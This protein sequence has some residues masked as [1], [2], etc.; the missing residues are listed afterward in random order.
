[1]IT[2][3]EHKLTTINGD[4]FAVLCRQYLN[5]KYPFVYPTGLVVG[6]DKSRIGT[7]DTF[8]PIE[9]YYLF[10]EITTKTENVLTKLKN[11]I[12]HCF[13]QNDVP[14][15]KIVKVILMFNGVHD[16]VKHEELKTHLSSYSTD[17]RLEVIDIRILAN[18][19]SQNYPSLAR[20]LGVP[21]DTDQILEVSEFIKDYEKS[22]FAT[23]LSNKFF[24]REAEIEQGLNSLKEKDILLISGYAGTGKTKLSLELTKIFL[25]ENKEYDLK[26]I[27]ANANLDI[28]EDLQTFLL[29]EKHYLLVLDDAN[30]LKNNLIQILNFQ[31]RRDNERRIKIILTVRNYVKREVEKFIEDFK[32]IE[33]KPFTRDELRKVLQSNEYNISDYYV[34]RIFNISKGNPRLAIM[35]VTAEQS[36]ELEKLNNPSQILE[37]YFSSVKESID[38]FENKSLLAVA[39]ILSFFKTINLENEI[40]VQEIEKYFSISKL[41]LEQNLRILYD[42]EIADEFEKIY[43]VADQIL[44]EYILYLVFIKEQEISFSSL[45]NAYIDKDGRFSLGYILKEQINNFSLESIGK[46]ISKDIKEGWE[47]V[48]NEELAISFIDDF[49]Y[50]IPYESLIYFDK[51]TKEIEA[52]NPIDYTFKV[53]NE[54]RSNTIGDK[55]IE[56]LIR[57]QYLGEELFLLALKVLVKYGLKSE[58]RFHKLLK[59]F[60]ERISMDRYSYEQGYFQQI[61]LFDF[62]YERVKNDHDFY[63]KIILFIAPTFLRDN[64]QSNH[65]TGEGILIGN[66]DVLLSEEQ[67]SF[68]EKL[69]KF[70]FKSYEITELKFNCQ[71]CLQEYSTNL[72]FHN[73]SVPIIKFDKALLLEFFK[74]KLNYNDFIDN[75]ILATYVDRLNWI[76]VD[77]ERKLLRNLKNRAYKLYQKLT[78]TI[79]ERKEKKLGHDDY[80]KY[81]LQQIAR[82]TKGF[83]RSD[84]MKIINDLNVIYKNKEF[85][86][87]RA[88]MLSQSVSRLLRVVGN[89]DFNLFLELFKKIFQSDYANE[90]HMNY[91]NKLRLNSE[92]VIQFRALL[93]KT[94]YITE[95]PNLQASVSP[96]NLIREDF[97]LFKKYLKN[98]K[99]TYFWFLER[100]LKRFTPFIEDS[101]ATYGEVLEILLRRATK[102]KIYVPN[103]FFTHIHE[104]QPKLFYDKINTVKA[105]YLKLDEYE[106][107]FD[108]SLEVL[109][110]ILEKAPDFVIS[111]MDLHFKDSSYLSKSSLLENDFRKLWKLENYEEVFTKIL[112]YSNPYHRISDNPDNITSIFT[113]KKEKHLDFLKSYLNKTTDKEGI[114][115]VFNIVVS[116]FKE[117]RFEFLDLILNKGIDFETFQRLD[118]A[119]LSSTFSGSRIPRLNHK[120][121]EYEKYKEHLQ[122]KSD[123]RM[124]DFISEL[125]RKIGWCNTIIERERKDEFLKDW[126]I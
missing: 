94:T 26:Y 103:N 27:R 18:E 48:G 40:Q 55:T 25:K 79:S 37:I 75:A 36:G 80:E 126:G 54:R 120:I 46:L 19:I 117:Y 12:S 41:T 82:Y 83:A 90:I 122:K 74:Q 110:I 1:M 76:Q 116:L 100:L 52:D 99:I 47:K 2:Q 11:D 34:E 16:T 108:Y 29:P 118:F 21:I 69:W 8:I 13:S 17:C 61:C 15:E 68:R 119:V 105:L 107:H 65:S 124:L 32:H 89:R 109:Q 28:W 81:K 3:I 93:S 86:N 38:S 97:E 10:V 106:R 87:E 77:D 70:I 114:F 35:A 95:L 96:R 59:A 50:Y 67:K 60:V 14:K 72:E 78:N 125:E 39:G 73:K 30:K 42:I 57:F 6:K 121:S 22:K 64:Y 113:D 115:T 20:K 51:I 44:G 101:Y 31:R 45:I 9:D 71:I 112:D 91:F 66:Y 33:L 4:D 56:I 104:E 58:L 85:H 102:E 84:Y 111:L 92:K 88:Y 98:K 123:I 7:P 53:F 49:Y 24:N 63:S 5:F 23:P 43:K 62:L